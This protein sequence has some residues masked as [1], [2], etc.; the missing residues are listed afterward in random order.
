MQIWTSLIAALGGGTVVA[1]ALI[2]YLGKTLS[3]RIGEAVKHEY[4][5]KL[6]DLKHQLTL[7]R[8]KTVRFDSE[9]FRS[10]GELWASLYDLRRAA[11]R[12]WERAT[13]EN[14]QVF[15]RALL[16][17]EQMIGRKRL[18]LEFDDANALDILVETMWN[19]RVGKER[20]IVMRRRGEP[21]ADFEIQQAIDDNRQWVDNYTTIMSRVE[22][23]FRTRL[24]GA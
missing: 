11:D 9:Q 19:L 14:F 12:L 17:A 1:T 4:S 23:D 20:L 8:D 22:M 15:G 2:A 3:I 18:L 10:Y 21:V 7:L 13:N 24:R 6:E 16:D 5:E